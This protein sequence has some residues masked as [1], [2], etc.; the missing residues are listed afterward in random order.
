MTTQDMKKDIHRFIPNSFHG[1]KHPYGKGYVIEGRQKATGIPPI[2]SSVAES[3]VTI[4]EAQAI[5]DKFN[6]LT[7]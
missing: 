2:C 1:R 4:E 3:F 6:K 5:A 7:V